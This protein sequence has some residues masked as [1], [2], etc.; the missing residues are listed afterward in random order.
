MVVTLRQEL[1]NE[2]DHPMVKALPVPAPFRGV[3]AY[4]IVRDAAKAIDFY[5][6][7]FGAKETMRID[8]P[9]GTIGHAE[10]AIGEGAIMLSDEHPQMGFTGPETLGGTP[11]SLMFY[12][13]DVDA[14]VEQAVAAGAKLM[15]PVRDQ[16][17]GDRSGLL[18]DPFGHIW[19]IATHIE[20]VSH[21]E[22]MRRASESKDQPCDETQKT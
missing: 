5:T 19:T 13:D 21:E 14:R 15:R 1:L 22:M 3:T 12:V 17:Y 2:T 20:D 10:L 18:T 7:A 6:R 9:N 11:V 4:L 8:G 16:F